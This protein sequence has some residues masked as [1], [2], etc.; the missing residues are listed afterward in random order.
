MLAMA[1]TALMLALPLLAGWLQYDWLRGEDGTLRAYDFISFY[2]AGA[3]ALSGDGALA[4]VQDAHRAVE[5]QAIG[6]D[7]GA[8]YGWYNP[9]FFLAAVS[10]VAFFPYVT[11]FLVWIAAGFALYAASIRAVMGRRLGYLLAC[12]NPA[13]LWNAAV[14]QNG[15]ISAALLAGVVLQLDRRPKLAGVLLG[16]LAY[17]PQFGILFPFVLLV[18]KRWATLISAALTVSVLVVL[19][20][21]AYGWD[22]WG[23]FLHNM[24]FLGDAVFAQSGIGEGK[25]QSLMMFLREQGVER[26]LA[27]GAHG[28]FVLALLVAVVW[29]R[30]VARAQ[31]IRDAVLVTGALLASPYLY[32]YDL[33]V[34]SVPAALLVKHML[35]GPVLRY[36]WVGL[37]AVVVL[38][39]T[40]PDIKAQSGLLAVL[41]MF[42]L[43]LRRR[44]LA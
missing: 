26:S 40:Q 13:V 35:R 14:G 31:E 21:A 6:H 44:R 30:R 2:A 18:E 41:L 39:Y 37:L 1:V 7:F 27:L 12:A 19:S 15:V 29:G 42:V 17:K 22:S 24:F 4:Y 38:I 33:V 9:P 28:V 8:Y 5:V 16:L 3:M 20:G 11:A 25:Q 43:L 23:A 32:V 10:L 36:E 34:L